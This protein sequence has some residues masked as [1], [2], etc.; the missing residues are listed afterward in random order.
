MDSI[1]AHFTPNNS[2]CLENWV[3]VPHTVLGKRLAPFCLLH[4]QWLEHLGSPL[5]FTSQQATLSDLE[6]AVLIC[7]SRSS[8][9]ILSRLQSKSPVLS[10]WRWRNR[11]KPLVGE[12]KAF[13]AYQ[14]DF[15]SLPEFATKD[16]GQTVEKIPCLLLQ[17]ATLIKETG[18]RQGDVLTM[19][20]GQVVWLNSAFS[21]LSTGETAVVS[22]KER[23][24]MAALDALENLTAGG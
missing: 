1:Q 21:Y 22:D 15:C 8:E 2:R 6:L 10:F 20:V 18:W 9:E 5:F 14:D 13:L 3:N 23:A 24:A 16:G 7:S 11:K 17:L 12:I 4:L 19:P